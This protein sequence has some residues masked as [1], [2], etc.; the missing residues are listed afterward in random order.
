MK[1]LAGVDDS[2]E[3]FSEVDESTEQHLHESAQRAV[4]T[5][6]GTIREWPDR[7]VD[8][9]GFIQARTAGLPAAA[10]TGS[11]QEDLE[12][13]ERIASATV[14]I[15]EAGVDNRVPFSITIQPTAGALTTTT[16][17]T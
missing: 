17:T 10:V 5:R 2:D 4:R 16:G 13:D 15:G 6:R 7:Y 8:L 1:D 14:V 11:V 3:G 9:A 12:E